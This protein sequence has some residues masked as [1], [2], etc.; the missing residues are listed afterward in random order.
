[1]IIQRFSIYILGTI[2]ALSSLD[3]EVSAKHTIIVQARDISN[4]PQLAQTK[5]QIF[6]GDENDNAPQF[7]Y[8]SSPVLSVIKKDSEG[9]SF[10]FRITYGWCNFCTLC[11]G[12]YILGICLYF[13]DRFV[14]VL[15]AVDIDIGLNSDI[16]YSI[17]G[18]RKE[19]FEIDE[20]T[21]KITSR[22]DLTVVRL[23]SNDEPCHSSVIS[24]TCLFEHH[25]TLCRYLHMAAS[26][27]CV[28]V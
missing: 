16:T 14:A 22:N 6:V 2:T 11:D 24:E 19:L 27:M 10:L 23:D 28:Q 20:N 5:V 13:T 4:S 3:R 12:F 15:P 26:F 1:M 17:T 25:L 21:A 7:L 9:N 18:G 8:M